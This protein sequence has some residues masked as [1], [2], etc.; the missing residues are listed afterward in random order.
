MA[1]VIENNTVSFSFQTEISESDARM[2]YR[3]SES[4]G[5]IEAI[6]VLR[7]RFKDMHISETKVLLDQIR[8][9]GE[10][11]AWTV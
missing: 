4:I 2:L 3:I 7:F 1:L 6:R 5:V 8:A 10:T 9:Y 11:N